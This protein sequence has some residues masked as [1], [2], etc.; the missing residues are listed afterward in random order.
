ML[1]GHPFNEPVSY[2]CYS[3]WATN[4]HT[5]FLMVLVGPNSTPTKKIKPI[6]HFCRCV[7][8]LQV[9]LALRPLEE[10]GEEWGETGPVTL[11]PS[12]TGTWA[13]QLQPRWMDDR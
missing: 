9:R 7:F 1:V 4:I 2:R 3:V 11:D 6:S 5:H 10:L 13:T 12:T 8:G